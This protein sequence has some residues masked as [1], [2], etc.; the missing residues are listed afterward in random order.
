MKKGQRKKPDAPVIIG[1]LKSDIEW[2]TVEDPEFS[3]DHVEGKLGNTRFKTVARNRRE[4]GISEL[5]AKGALNAAQVA[6]AD[7]FRALFEAMGG[8][9][10]RA[11]DPAKEAVDGGRIP[12]PISTRAFQAGVELKKAAEHVQKSHG[13]YGYKL[14]C[15]VAGEGRTIRELTQTRRQRDTMT[16]YLRMCLTSLAEFWGFQTQQRRA[17]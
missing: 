8:A 7:R 10:A 13:L 16:D 1:T 12:D 5:A 15:Y 9:G 6:A 11:I 14:V 4:S 17:G 2:A 3:H